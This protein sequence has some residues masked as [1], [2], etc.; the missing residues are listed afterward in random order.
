L[1][2]FSKVITV[3]GHNIVQAITSIAF[4]EGLCNAH[5]VIFKIIDKINPTE[6]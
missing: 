1:R 6:L 2:V 5:N 4:K 3:V